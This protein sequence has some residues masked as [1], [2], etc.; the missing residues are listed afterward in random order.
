MARAL[1]A[2]AQG[3]FTLALQYHAFSPLVALLCSAIVTVILL[4]LAVGSALKSPQLKAGM[5]RSRQLPMYLA[6]SVFAYHF[7]RLWLWETQ[8]T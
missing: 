5:A 7:T 4:E 1:G 8:D 2:I 3:N 6:V